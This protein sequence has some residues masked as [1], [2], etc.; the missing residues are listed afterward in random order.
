[1]RIEQMR[2]CFWVAVGVAV[3]D[4]TTKALVVAFIDPGV[5][6]NLCPGFNLALTYNYGIAFGLV[7]SFPV[8][9]AICQT[10]SVPAVILACGVL[11]QRD[12]SSTRL[13]SIAAGFFIGCVLGN[14]SNRWISGAVVDFVDLYI[15][16]YHWYKF[17]VAD[18][19]GCL[20]AGLIWLWIVR[21][22]RQSRSFDSRG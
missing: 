19:S 11:L 17:N 7:E 20:G 10:C 1:M 12:H 8:L 15:A 4:L 6:I 21:V 16:Q 14:A 13:L 18:I 9:A 2:T 5:K 22:S 3:L